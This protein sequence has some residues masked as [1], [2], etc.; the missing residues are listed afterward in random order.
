[1]V[2]GFL[3]ALLTVGIACG[4][5]SV[6][7]LS[8]LFMAFDMSETHNTRS[9]LENLAKETMNFVRGNSYNLEIFH[10]VK[11]LITSVVGTGVSISLALL[12]VWLRD[13]VTQT[14]MDK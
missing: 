8:K 5:A 10:L 14:L 13:V 9:F 11:R 7:C 3:Y 1:M 2:D 4:V 12:L 6:I